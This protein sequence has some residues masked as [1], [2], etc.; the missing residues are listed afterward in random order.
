MKIENGG[1]RLPGK[2]KF[3]E[4]I[5][6]IMY[7]ESD[8][9]IFTIFYR[10]GKKVKKESVGLQIKAIEDLLDPYYFFRP[11]KSFLVNMLSIKSFRRNGKG[12]DLI[13]SDDIV[14]PLAK[15][16]DRKDEFFKRLPFFPH[17]IIPEGL[18]LR[19]RSQEK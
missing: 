15:R 2:D 13:L 17:I 18:R 12:F 16:K 1:L 10:E 7:I 3:I 6:S 11:H 5:L 19:A 4:Y 8:D 14:I 9:M